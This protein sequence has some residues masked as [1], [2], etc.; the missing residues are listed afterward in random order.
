MTEIQELL[1]N[2]LHKADPRWGSAI[3]RFKAASEKRTHYR[4][5][6]GDCQEC[7][8]TMGVHEIKK[9]PS[10]PCR[11][12]CVRGCGIYETRP[13]SCKDYECL[14]LSGITPDGWKPKKYGIVM[15]IANIDPKA[16]SRDASTL[17]FFLRETRS[18]AFAASPE[19]YAQ[20]IALAANLCLATPNIRHIG[21]H[22]W[23]AR[24]MIVYKITREGNA[25]QIELVK[26]NL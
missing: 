17:G 26:Q 7:C 15:D 1:L 24:D 13:Q 22:P 25:V 23:K 10:S 3:R 5:S 19:R 18:G 16:K 8:T 20:S 6:C 9:P 21:L 2:A 12:L 14:W 4:R 11:H